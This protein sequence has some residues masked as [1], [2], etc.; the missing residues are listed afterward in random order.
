MK[1]IALAIQENGM[2]QNVSHRYKS[3]EYV[4]GR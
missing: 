2:A 1:Q 4:M 3:T